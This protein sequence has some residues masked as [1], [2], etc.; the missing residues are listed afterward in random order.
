MDLFQVH[1][2]KLKRDGY[3]K[4]N[5]Q[6]LQEALNKL[7][8]EHIIGNIASVILNSRDAWAPAEFL[9]VTQPRG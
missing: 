8:K 6:E 1:T 2:V 3:G 4:V 5:P 9:V 7:S